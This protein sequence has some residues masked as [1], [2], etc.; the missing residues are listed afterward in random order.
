MK[1]RNGL[2]RWLLIFVVSLMVL[3]ACGSTQTDTKDDKKNNKKNKQSELEVPVFSISDDMTIVIHN[4]NDEQM[5]EVFLDGISIGTLTLSESGTYVVGY[6]TDIQLRGCSPDGS[7]VT[8]MTEVIRI[9]YPEGMFPDAD[10]WQ[11]D[12][13]ANVE[14]LPVPQVSVNSIGEL[15]I[16]PEEHVRDYCV[17]NLVTGEESIY[18]PG[19]KYIVRPNEPVVVRA[20]GD[21]YAGYDDS[22]NSEPIQYE[23]E[24]ITFSATENTLDNLVDNGDGSYTLTARSDRGKLYEFRVE[25]N[26]TPLDNAWGCIPSGS[27]FYNV[28]A[29]YGIFAIEMSRTEEDGVVSAASGFKLDGSDRVTSSE[30][31]DTWFY[32]MGIAAFHRVDSIPNYFGLGDRN[33]ADPIAVKQFTLYFNGI[34]TVVDHFTT[35]PY[36]Y[37][38]TFLPGTP[39]TT[40]EMDY[41]LVM[42]LRNGDLPLVT[43]DYFETVEIGVLKNANG[44][45]IED[46][47]NHYMQ[48]GDK[49]EVTLADGYVTDVSLVKDTLNDAQNANQAMPKKYSD[50]VGTMN[51]LAV[52]IVWNDQ[53]ELASDKNIENIKRAFGNVM[54]VDGNVTV[55]EPEDNE[56]L[57]LSEYFRIASYDQLTINAFVT[58]W[59]PHRLSFKESQSSYW[60]WD[61]PDEVYNWVRE[62]YPTLDISRF[63]NDKDGII[64]EI[65]FINTGNGIGK[66]EALGHEFWGAY[67]YAKDYG[68]HETQTYGTPEN[69]VVYHYVNMTLGHLLND[70]EDAEKGIDTNV[71][72]HEFGHTIA[73]MDYYNTGNGNATFL[74]GYDMQD[75]NVGDWNVYSKYCAGWL[76]PVVA[77]E[78]CFAGS[79]TVEFTL[80]SSALY[81]DALLIPAAGYA[82][83]KTPYDEYLILDLFTPEGLH[84]NDSKL[85]G[86]EN[87]VGVRIYHVSDLMEQVVK[88]EGSSQLKYGMQHY[89]NN[90]DTIYSKQFGMHQIEIVSAT[91]KNRFTEDG[92][93]RPEDFFTEGDR[94]AVEDFDEFFYNGKMDNGL[95]FGYEI[96][97]TSISQVNGETVATI[98]VTRK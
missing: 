20:I 12:V 23:A 35:H 15:Q 47:K 27:F 44:D 16:V 86:L 90:S 81:G 75:G 79:D 58:D 73:V 21:V 6:D 9:P 19:Q 18:T 80:R 38:A 64:D 42:Y 5:Y 88:E 95:A 96:A 70:Y 37:R 30:Q 65:I 72:I 36:F 54:D 13:P 3:T 56:I 26:V 77:D 59:Y 1:R 33:G 22:D 7:E 82:Y 32:S 24:S 89:T 67:R 53:T 46:A 66:A 51:V 63:D 74:G 10:A 25:G 49:L 57:S 93:F 84:E 8:E 60:M 62:T 83:N 29:I 4:T 34:E 94:F 31:M 48:P 61:E 69:P 97:V 2:W 14:K 50:T 17:T 41:P 87:E 43:A 92:N 11:G 85:F 55:Y 98:R 40:K 45:V 52:P 76:T 68:G 28:D 71:L 78:N 39:Y 91:G